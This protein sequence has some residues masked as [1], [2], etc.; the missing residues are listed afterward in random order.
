MQIMIA[1]LYLQRAQMTVP[2]LSS[3]WEGVFRSRRR[4]APKGLLLP[5]HKL[6]QG[7]P[8]SFLG[9]LRTIR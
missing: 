4:V 9:R 7:R 5:L 1:E 3:V 8:V 6:A 2:N